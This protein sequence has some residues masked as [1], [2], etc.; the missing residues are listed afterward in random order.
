MSAVIAWPCQLDGSGH[1]TSSLQDS[2]APCLQGLSQATRR[3]YEARILRFVEW[4]ELGHKHK[5]L[6]RCAVREYL[7]ALET[8]G[9]TPQVRNQVLAAVKRLVC[10]AAERGV[11]KPED[12]RG[13][14]ALHSVKTL[15]MKTGR[16]LTTDQTAALLASV[17]RTKPAGRRDACVLAL[18]LG[19]GLRRAE[20][21]SLDTSQLV[22]RDGKMLIVNLVGKGGRIRSLAVPA[23]AKELIEEWKG[24]LK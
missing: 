14:D 7:H 24:E 13:I 16:W 17:D 22:V 8:A 20:A 21:C 6:T 15:G 23:W 1:T 3:A 12:A 9:A 5:P 10:E 18:L 19:C 11:V 2:V 4:L